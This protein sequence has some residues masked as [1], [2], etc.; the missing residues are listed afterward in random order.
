[1]TKTREHYEKIIAEAQAGLAELDKVGDG[2]PRIG[3]EYWHVT[4]DGYVCLEEWSGNWLD[5]GRWEHGNVYLTKEATEEAAKWQKLHT[6]MMRAADGWETGKGNYYPQWAHNDGV[7]DVDG[8]K[9]FQAPNTPYFRTEEAAEKAVK[10]IL[11]D[12]A[13]FY[14]TYEGNVMPRNISFSMTKQQFLDGSKD[15]TRRMG[16]LHLQG[17]DVLCAVEKAMG[18][19]KG[20]KI[21]RFGLIRVVQA[22]REPLKAITQ[23][24]VVREGFPH[25]STDEFIKFFCKGHGC[26]PE[27]EVTRI[28]FE[29]LP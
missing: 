13:E 19:K 11:G 3:K 25:W 29:R 18:L 6:A 22:N 5:D 27:D 7:V 14:L 20:E 21:N 26:R 1:M 23:E 28:E 2:R 17:G 8:Y 15:V 16:W 24:D 9:I 10:D 4:G 12:D